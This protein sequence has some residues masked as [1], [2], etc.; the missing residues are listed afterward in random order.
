MI[1]L[2]IETSGVDLLHSGIWQIGAVD[3]DDPSRVFLDEARI[4]E[5]DTVEQGALRVTG[6]TEEYLRDKARQSQRELL[7]KFFIWCARSKYKNFVCQNPQFDVAFLKAKCSKYNLRF[8]FHYRS[9]D[10]HSI[11]NFKHLQLHGK[12][13]LE[14][15]HSDMGL[16]NILSF[17]G[18]KD[19]RKE[20]N[21]LEDA[22]LTAECFSRVVYGKRLLPEFNGFEIPEKLKS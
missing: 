19:E 15:D 13:L 20:H 21:A 11:A 9:F 8:P 16:T 2:D 22:K 10:L 12:F 6:K 18:M 17:C 7:L 4:D 14:N 1:V 5:D 3:L